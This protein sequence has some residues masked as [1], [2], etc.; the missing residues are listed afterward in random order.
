M[1][2]VVKTY[3]MAPWLPLDSSTSFFDFRIYSLRVGELYNFTV[4]NGNICANAARLKLIS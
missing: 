4:L 1:E 3:L 2:E